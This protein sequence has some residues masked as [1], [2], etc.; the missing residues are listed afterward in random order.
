MNYQDRYKNLTL[1]KAQE[2]FLGGREVLPQSSIPLIVQ[3]LEN[4]QY[5]IKIFGKNLFPGRTNLGHHDLLHILLNQGLKQTNEAFVLG[6]TM[7]STGQMTWVETWLYLGLMN[8]FG[9]KL[10]RYNKAQR[11]V[12][13]IAVS[14]GSFYAKKGIARLDR[15]PLDLM[16][17]EKVSRIREK[18][19]L[20]DEDVR[21]FNLIT[22]MAMRPQNSSTSS[23]VNPKTSR[24]KS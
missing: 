13:M 14:L 23:D 17:K 21:S 8:I 18:L 9:S 11:K 12:F 1:K 16:M 10:Y 5:D 15:F 3:L 22:Q 19:G 6:F 24:A 4:P 7:G 2:V 20:H